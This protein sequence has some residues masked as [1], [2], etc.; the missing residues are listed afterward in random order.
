MATDFNS[1]SSFNLFNNA[2]KNIKLKEAEY[3]DEENK[4]FYIDDNN[5]F[6][7]LD[8][9]NTIQA[10]YGKANEYS[11]FSDFDDNNTSYYKD[12]ESIFN[13]LG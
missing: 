9:T 10:E 3:Q 8:D 13:D 11:L 7:N 4:N 1:N 6:V 5:E 2:F 12:D